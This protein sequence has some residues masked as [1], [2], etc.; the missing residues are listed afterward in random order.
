MAARA[1]AIDHLICF[2]EHVL[3]STSPGLNQTR[4]EL[5]YR[6]N[7]RQESGEGAG[8]HV[9][10]GQLASHVLSDSTGDGRTLDQRRC[11]RQRSRSWAVDDTANVLSDP[12]VRGGVT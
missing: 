4:K 3:T 10:Q 7:G 9:G 1:D 12:G 8:G 5:D 6:G 2:L 11:G